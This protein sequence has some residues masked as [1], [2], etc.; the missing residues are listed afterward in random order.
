[1]SHATGPQRGERN[2]RCKFRFRLDGSRLLY[3]LVGRNDGAERTEETL[4]LYELAQ[5][6]VL[7]KDLHA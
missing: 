7:S 1:M 2:H 5:I 4:M 6:I 3:S